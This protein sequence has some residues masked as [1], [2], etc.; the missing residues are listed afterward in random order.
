MDQASKKESMSKY[1]EGDQWALLKKNFLD[2]SLKDSDNDLGGGL[3]NRELEYNEDAFEF[4]KEDIQI[5]YH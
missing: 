1:V 3:S 2:K 5:R 4:S